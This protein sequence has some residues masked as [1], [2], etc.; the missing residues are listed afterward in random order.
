MSEYPQS[1]IRDGMRIDWDVPIEMDDGVTLRCDVYR[2]P[3]DGEYPVLITYGP[4]GKWLHFEDGF[5]HQWTKM[6]EEHPDVPAESTNQYQ[7]WEVADPEK[8]V[9]DGYAIVRVDSRGAGRSEG[10]LDVWSKR[11][12]LDFAQCIE[13]A[14]A[15]EWSNGKVGINGISYFAMNQYPVAA[16]QPD[17]LEAICAWEG[18]ADFYRDASHNG[19]I[20]TTWAERWYDRQV[21]PLQNGMGENGYRSRMTGGL[22]SG[23]ETLTEEELGANRA[24]FHEDFISH[25][26]ATDQYWQDRMPDW[27]Q[28][29]VPMLSAGNWG[30]H[31]LHLRGNTEAF[32]RAASEEKFLEIHGDAHWTHFYTDY[33]REL[34]K[35]FLDYYLKGEDN[36]WGEQP[37]VQLQVRHPGEEFEERYEEAWPIPRTEWTKYYLHPEGNE[38]STDAQESEGSVTYDALG[39]GVTFLTDPLEEETELTGPV[40]SKLFV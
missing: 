8:W 38:L 15:Q 1:E 22:V 9:P 37:P 5:E 40:S 3:E 20:Y 7:V 25:D 30:G 33:G 17:C 6:C 31:G 34:Q 23:P 36:G 18:A 24:D 2:P 39:D 27:S 26:L 19:G 16:M 11:E 35:R 32:V 14:G 10:Y 12:D 13:W 21:R 28:V 29:E 4:Y